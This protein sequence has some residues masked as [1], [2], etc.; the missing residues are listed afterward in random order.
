MESSDQATIRAGQSRSEQELHDTSKLEGLKNTIGCS[1]ISSPWCNPHPSRKKCYYRRAK[2]KV[3]Q[4]P[5]SLESIGQAVGAVYK[6]PLHKYEWQVNKQGLK[7]FQLEGSERQT[8][9]PTQRSAALYIYTAKNSF[10][11][12]KLSLFQWLLIQSE[13]IWIW[14]AICC[15]CWNLPVNRFLCTPLPRVSSP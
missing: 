2:W 5:S 3:N 11:F 13:S 1:E 9:Q 6:P 7:V 8:Q 4:K 14:K 15:R 10:N 12:L